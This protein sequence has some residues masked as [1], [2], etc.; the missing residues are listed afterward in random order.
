MKHT[1]GP[2]RVVRTGKLVIIG[3]KVI[4]SVGPAHDPECEANARLIAA[5]PALLQAVRDL[6][7][8]LDYFTE[9]DSELR[10][11]ARDKTAAFRVLLANITGDPKEP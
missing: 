10:A 7:L 1:Q 5:A 6:L 2:W 3:T 9:G 8:A 11:H 4:A